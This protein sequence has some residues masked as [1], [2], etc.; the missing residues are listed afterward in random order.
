MTGEAKTEDKNEIYMSQ[1]E[2]NLN[3]VR[4]FRRGDR[5]ESNLGPVMQ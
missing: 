2:K 5:R 4:D 3:A 1:L